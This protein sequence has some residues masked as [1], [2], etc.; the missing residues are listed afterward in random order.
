MKALCLLALLP[1]V[2]AAQ[3]HQVLSSVSG[4]P[5]TVVTL[6]YGDGKP[7]SYEGYEL[8][9][10]GEGLPAQVG[11]TDAQGRV[12]FLPGA[13]RQWHL[14]AFSQDGHGVDRRFE[15]AAPQGTPAAAGDRTL[16]HPALA[17]LGGALL[18]TLFALYQLFLRRRP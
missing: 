15:V 6:R 11:R 7:F 9:R 16:L 10:G 14:R 8:F 5:A 13:A 17:I 12:V 1:A 2:G 18:L 4:A 3:A